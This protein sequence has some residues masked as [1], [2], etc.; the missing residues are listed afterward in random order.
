MRFKEFLVLESG[1]SGDSGSDWF[2]GNSV[3]PSD[4]FDWQ[5][6]FPNPADF[7]FLQ[8]RWKRERDE[9]GRK[10][11]N[12]DPQD[13]IDRKFVSLKSNTMP[14]THDLKWKHSTKERP[15]FEVNNDAKMELIGHGKN[16]KVTSVLWKINDLL[17]KTDELNRTFGKFEPSHNELPTNFDKPW[18]PYSG[19]VKMKY[20]KKKKYAKSL[21][22]F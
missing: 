1:D 11:H 10:F 18:S 5:Y 16:G 3:Y 4:A 12:I 19:E 21:N 13:T 22:N 14:P 6:E 9:W 7:A 2:Y 20:P 17:D 8:A 15:N